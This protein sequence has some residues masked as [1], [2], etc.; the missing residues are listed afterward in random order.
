MANELPE[1][2]PRR[3]GLFGGSFDPIH[4]GHLALTAGARA[5]AELDEVIFIPC[6]RS[7]HKDRPTVATDKQRV[8]MILEAIDD[9]DWA[10]VSTVEMDRSSPSYSWETAEH[11]AAEHPEAD[12]Y[13][14]LGTDQWENIE[15]WSRPGILCDLLTFI[16]AN[17]NETPV[18]RRAD[19][20]QIDLPFDHPA[21]STAIRAGEGLADWLHPEVIAY[22]AEHAIYG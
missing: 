10:T 21:S 11:F 6:D 9:L 8:A 7:P 22:I 16:I 4:N 2:R 19:W 1:D 3:I 13:W 20:S 14:I 12:L 15:N 5:I 18:R 17:R